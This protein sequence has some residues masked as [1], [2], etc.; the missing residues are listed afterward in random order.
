MIFWKKAS[1]HVKA[2]WNVGS[3][4]MVKQKTRMPVIN[5]DEAIV[6]LRPMYFILTVK[7]ASRAPGTPTID[8]MA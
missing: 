3:D 6:P 2:S 1:R 8:V 5:V 4:E 7:Y